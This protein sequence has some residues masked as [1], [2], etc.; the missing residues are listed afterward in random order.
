MAGPTIIAWGTHEQKARYLQPLLRGD[1]VWC[2]G[3][4]E[5][6]SGSDLAGARTRA[7]LDGDEW[8][9]NGQKVWSSYA[10]IADWCILVVRTDRDAPK[11]ARPVVPAG[12]HAR[13]R[14]SR[15]GRCA[16][17]PATRS[18]TRSSSPT[19]GCRATSIL[20]EPGDG[21]KVAMTTLLH[22]RGTLGF[23]LTARLEVAVEQA[24]RAGPAEASGRQ[25]GR[26]TTRVIRDAIAQSWIDLQALRF[27]NYS[28]LTSLVK[29]GVPGPEGSVAKLHWSETNQ[30]LTKLAL[31]IAGPGVAAR[32]RR[33]G[34]G[35]LLAV[36]AAAQPRQH[37]RGRHLGDPA[38]HHRRARRRPAEVP[39]SRLPD[40]PCTTKGLFVDFAFSDEQEML[41]AAA[42]E[43]LD[44]QVPPE[45][46]VA[47]AETDPAQRAG[48]G[49]SRDLD[50]ARRAG[51]ARSRGLPRRG[52][53]VR[54]GRA[55]AAA[56]ALS[57]RRSRWPGPRWSASSRRRSRGPRT[58]SPLLTSKRW[59]TTADAAGRLTGV[60]R[61]VPDLALAERVVVVAADGLYA[62]DV[63]AAQVTPLSTVDRLRP[64]A[65]LTLD[66]TPGERVG[67]LD[68]LPLIRRRA[69]AALACEAVGVA[70]RALDLAAEHAKTRQQ[71]GRIIG[72]YQAVCHQVADI[73][74]ALALARS[75]ATWAA[76][77]VS[78]GDESAE[79]ACAAA[80]S[81][82]GEAAVAR[83]RERDPG[84]RRHRLHLRAHPAPL[85]QAGAVDQ[86]LRGQ[87]AARSGP[88]SPRRCSTAGAAL[89]S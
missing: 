82:A 87:R 55:R 8:V 13:R 17:S 21:W 77:A 73:F 4:S 46:V 18:S 26:P 41:R 22:E 57:C 69:F 6:G 47:L 89:A 5:P 32:R 68:L 23:A 62:V 19:S 16:R 56:G 33:R 28:S 60:K 49:G 43:Y 2:Q 25:P 59:A 24:D 84:A 50:G 15:C 12:R 79:M 37:D 88:S 51:L 9:V 36:P 34:L 42:R 80:K 1:E 31:S 14:V 7:E 3:F 78:A 81:A 66:G 83:L 65:E 54:G 40:A 86:R 45:R 20:G 11:H 39:L 67:D 72:T 61:L 85:L 29:T 74:I 75:L 64:L 27:T 48:A 30:R 53:A 71:F 10:H 76:W 58:P 52:S 63:A 38:Q 70:Q 35:R 44:R